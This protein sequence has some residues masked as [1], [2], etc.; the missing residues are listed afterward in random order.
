MKNLHLIPTSQPSR[1]FY[2]AGAKKLMLSSTA[3]SFK[4][5]ERSPH[6]IY[7][8]ND[9][10]IKERDWYF[11]TES[12]RK[13]ESK[14]EANDLTDI[15]KKITLTTD[16]DLIK[17]GVQ[18]IDDQFLEWFV[19]NPSCERVEVEKILLGKVEG[20][21][22]SVSKYKIIIPQE[23]PKQETLEEVAEKEA[24]LFYEKGSLDW[25]KYRQVF[26]EGAKWQEQRMYSEEE[27]EII[28]TKLMHEVHTGDICYGNNVIDF[29]ISP[30]KWLEQFKKK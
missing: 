3:V 30:R 4:I 18:A 10:L 9:E 16:P 22:M 5:F 17:D 21:T 26:I 19:K 11:I 13:C 12:I 25:N 28:I 23:E 29:K 2:G 7:I 15:C 6:H 24:S 20:T 27:V 1:L 14:Y 8:T